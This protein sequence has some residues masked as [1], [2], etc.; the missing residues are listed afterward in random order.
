MTDA[1]PTPIAKPDDLPFDLARR[2][3]SNT[4]HSPDD[5]A[6]AD[7]AAYAD[8]VNGLHAAL[9]PHAATEAQKALLAGE[10][11]R[12]KENYLRLYSA[13]L[14]AHSR[15]ASP[16]ITGPANFPVRRQQKRSQAADSR[17]DELLAWREK[18]R[19]AV[20]REVMES[21]PAEV[22]ED[23][24]WRALS[25]DIRGSLA[26]IAAIDEQGSPYTRASFVN[27]IAG[28]VERL[29]RAGE[30]SLV[31][32]AIDLIREYN[33]AHAKP[34]IS[35]RHGFWALA[36][37]ARAAKAH[38]DALDEEPGTVVE[39][40]GIRI[41]ANRAADRVRIVFDAKP[42]EAMRAKLKGEGRRWSP[43]EEAWQRKMT[44]AAIYSAKKLTG[45]G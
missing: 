19:A 15:C 21:R 22:V 38:D 3:Y 30:V 1:P 35:A 23:E 13:Y 31:E 2:A 27:S 32:K 16:M 7:Q 12:Y 42:D 10:V 20:E 40:Q 24:R 9:A 43:S 33:D 44:N 41:V 6:R 39:G 36:E 34:A 14:H 25:R 26:E 5:R 45:L 37:T 18:A 8:D 28:K 29:A 11:A 17:R 4:S